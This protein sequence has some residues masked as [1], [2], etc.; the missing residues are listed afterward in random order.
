MRFANK[1]LVVTGGASGIGAATARRYTDE[2]G[3]VAVVDL[4][5]EK[6]QATAAEIPGA[7]AVQCDVSD[8]ASV[9]AAIAQTREEL[10]RIDHLFNAPDKMVKESQDK[11]ESEAKDRSS[12]KRKEKLAEFR[13]CPLKSDTPVVAVEGA[14]TNTTPG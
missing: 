4:D 2:G 8:E 3:R 5:L 14:N 1:V 6:A 10:G 7:I 9:I 13:K 11:R 12:K